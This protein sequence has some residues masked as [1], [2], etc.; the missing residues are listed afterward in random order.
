MAFLLA[1]CALIQLLRRGKNPLA[2]VFAILCSIFAAALLLLNS[3]AAAKLYPIAVNLVLLLFFSLSLIYPPSAAERFARLK[4]P[5]IPNV[6]VQYC[7]KVTIVWCLFFIFNAS[8]SFATTRF[9]TQVWTIYNG[10]A[11]YI[12]IGLLFAVEFG[13][14]TRLIKRLPHDS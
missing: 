1:V 6:A 12:L 7:R 5:D 11:S 8:V 9:S 10:F 4:Q 13:Y 2:L 3:V 14:R